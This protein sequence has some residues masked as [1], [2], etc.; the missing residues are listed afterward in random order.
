[1]TVYQE[2]ISQIKN[3]CYSNDK[4][5]KTVIATRHFIANNFEKDL[6]LDFLSQ[7]RFMSKY[8]LQRLFKRY[9]GLTPRQYLT[10]KRLEKSKENLKNGMSVTET[11]F[12]VGFE[13]LGSFSTLFK[14]KTGKSPKEFQKEQLSRSKLQQEF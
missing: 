13:S 6:K 8:H 12:A 10:D 3:I 7:K 2:K 11:C 1:M 4:Q 5:I 14:S 9:Y